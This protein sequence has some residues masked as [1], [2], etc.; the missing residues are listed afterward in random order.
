MP[1]GADNC[2]VLWPSD[3]QYPGIVFPIVACMRGNRDWIDV[4]GSPAGYNEEACG[5]ALASTD[6][7]HS[8]YMFLQLHA[9]G[10]LL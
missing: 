4:V 9:L 1:V 6:H 5:A 2:R 10:D 8:S 7:L 3:V